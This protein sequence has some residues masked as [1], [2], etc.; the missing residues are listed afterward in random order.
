MCI[1]ED[2]QVKRVIKTPKNIFMVI[3]IKIEDTGNSAFVLYS[4]HI[5]QRL[6]PDSLFDFLLYFNLYTNQFLLNIYGQD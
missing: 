1:C 4:F 5:A 6:L 2:K 3:L